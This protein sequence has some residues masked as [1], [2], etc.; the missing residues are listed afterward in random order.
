LHS[1]WG[2]RLSGPLACSGSCTFWSEAGVGAQ[3]GVKFGASFSILSS[4]CCRKTAKYY[5][6]ARGCLRFMR[7]KGEEM[8]PNGDALVGSLTSFFEIAGR[9]LLTAGSSY[10]LGS[11]RA[12]PLS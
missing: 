1:G 4:H 6:I 2:Y 12:N 9:I 3:L 10:T 5:C 7:T 8:E 11:P